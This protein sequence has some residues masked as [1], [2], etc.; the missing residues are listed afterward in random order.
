MEKGI[1]ISRIAQSLLVMVSAAAMLAA[2]RGPRI[3]IVTDMEGVAGVNSWEQVT[4]GERR[5]EETRKLLMGEV[6]AAI[7]GAVAAGASEVS[8]WDGHGGSRHLNVEDLHPLGQ[9]IQG[10]PTPPDYYLSAGRFE[11]VFI[12]GQHAMAGTK[13][14][15]LSHTQSLRVKELT[16]NG[17]PVGEMGQ[18]AAIAGHFGIP[19]VMLSGDQ[20]AC[21]EF[22][23]LQPRGETVAVKRLAGTASAWSLSAAEA[24]KRIREAARRAVERL[25]EFQPWRID[26]PVELRFEFHPEK[27][28]GVDKEVPPRVYQGANVLEAYRAWLKR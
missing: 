16:L 7:E 5:Y 23:G 9:L 21:E 6:N 27:K 17:K 25:A 26:G 2:E 11:G 28:E 19:V 13:T 12:I 14:G 20:A 3:Y 8:V 22:R 1:R 24:R 10:A 15:L 18:I 4:V